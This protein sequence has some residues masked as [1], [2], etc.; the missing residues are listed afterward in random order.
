MTRG[1][2]LRKLTNSQVEIGKEIVVLGMGVREQVWGTRENSRS[3]M[4]KG[5]KVSSTRWVHSIAQIFN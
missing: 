4:R 1:R 2:L 5:T 3:R